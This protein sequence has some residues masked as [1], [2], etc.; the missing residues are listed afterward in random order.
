MHRNSVW[1]TVHLK[2]YFL[3]I[4]FA[5][6]LDLLVLREAQILDQFLGQFDISVA[7]E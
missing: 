5:L 2:N 1:S 7:G 6:L 3:N 4:S